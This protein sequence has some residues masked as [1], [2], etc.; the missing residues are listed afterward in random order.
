MSHRQ[1]GFSLVELMVT[2][3][4]LALLLMAAVPSFGSWIANS[5]VRSVAEDVANGLRMAQSEAVRRNRPVAFVMT[6]STPAKGATPAAN[7]KNWYVQ[8]LP[9]SSSGDTAADSDYIQGG[10]FATQSGVTISSTSSVLCFGSMG[11]V[12]DSV[13]TAK[14][15]LG[16]NC[17]AA[18]DKSYTVSNTNSDRS[19]KVTVGVGGQVRLCDPAKT[20]DATH[21]DGCPASS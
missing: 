18:G 19:L 5:R 8:A 3:A 7:G 6:N 11:N 16:E 10:S 12:S 1:Q 14:T 17:S 21:P 13:A 20:L 15:A 2:I 4:I 9:L